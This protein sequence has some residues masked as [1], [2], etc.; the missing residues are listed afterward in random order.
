SSRDSNGRI[1]EHGIHI[2]LGFYENA[3]RMMRE[4]YAEVQQK[5]WGPQQTD[6]DKVL[7]HG[8]FDEAFFVEPQVGVASTDQV[9]VASKNGCGDWKVWSG[10]LPPM[11]GLPGTPLDE[12]SN[13]C[14]LSAYL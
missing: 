9:G 6:R 3:F 10:S 7:P 13:P 12:A 14:T 4:C 1:R 8:S 11:D 5:K 2:W